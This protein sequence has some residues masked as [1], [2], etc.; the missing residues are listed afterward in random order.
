VDRDGREEP[1]AADPARYE[2]FMLSPDG[3]RLAVRIVS[4]V[5]IYD[6][7]RDTSTRLTF[8][9]DEVGAGFPT[10]TP[11]GTRVAFG[12]PLSWKRADG[13]G[14]VERLDDRVTRLPQAFSPDGTTLVFEDLATTGGA[15]L[16]VL[17]LEGDSTATLVVNGEF[18]E[19]NAALSPDGRWLA[20]NSDETGRSEV[21]VRPFPD[22]DSGRWQISSDGGFWPVWSPAGGEL[23][24]RT[25]TGVMARAFESE[26]TFTPGAL[27]RLFERNFF[28]AAGQRRIAVSPDGQRFLLRAENADSETAPSQLIVVQN[29][30]EELKRL[31]PVP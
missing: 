7:V 16:G 19:T 1:V 4:A 9:S 13:I 31:V 27:S 11:D 25:L 6:L 26:P 2:E 29:F 23:F 22:V 14:A 3:T 5:W 20:Y 24:Y 8:E 21:F 28:G 10:W 30:F 18:D 12:P 15:G 17:T